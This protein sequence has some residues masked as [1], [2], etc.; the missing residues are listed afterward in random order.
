MYPVQYPALNKRPIGIQLEKQNDT[1]QSQTP[2]QIRLLDL[3]L[4]LFGTGFQEKEDGLPC[5]GPL[6]SLRCAEL[7]LDSPMRFRMTRTQKKHCTGAKIRALAQ[8]WKIF[9][10]AA[11]TRTRDPENP[12]HETQAL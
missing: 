2:E 4:Q 6:L 7:D 3:Q 11:A 9:P 12:H 5:T 1:E 8:P 10:R